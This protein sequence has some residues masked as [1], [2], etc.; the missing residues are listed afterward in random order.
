M[1]VGIGIVWRIAQNFTTIAKASVKKP[2][3]SMTPAP[4]NP[5]QLKKQRERVLL[6][7]ASSLGIRDHVTIVKT[8]YADRSL[9]LESDP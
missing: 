4:I 5:G 2:V 8:F 1:D 7:F 3:S 9:I 6:G